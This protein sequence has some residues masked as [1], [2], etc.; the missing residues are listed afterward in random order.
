MSIATLKK[1]SNAIHSNVSK[2]GFYLNGILRLPTHTI[3]RTPTRTILKGTAPTGYGTGSHCRIKG[4]DAR[5]CKNKY[6]IVIHNTGTPEVQT[7]VKRSTMNTFGMLEKRYMGIL[8][9]TYPNTVVSGKPSISHSEY[10]SER[11]RNPFKC[12]NKNKNKDKEKDHGT[13][14]HYVANLTPDTYRAYQIKLTSKC[15]NTDVNQLLVKNWTL[16]QH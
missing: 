13:C 2:H 3:I 6:P 1:K 12:K 14:P 7:G 11:E 10:T 16:C 15:L 5:Y 4:I 8:H 9:G